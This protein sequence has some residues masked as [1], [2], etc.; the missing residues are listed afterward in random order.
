MTICPHCLGS[1]CI[2]CRE[3]VAER[4]VIHRRSALNA[5]DRRLLGLMPRRPLRF[6]LGGT[7][8]PRR[9]AFG[10]SVLPRNFQFA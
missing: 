5:A 6:D 10:A 4:A 7:P 9:R 2:H 1:G 8:L 3:T